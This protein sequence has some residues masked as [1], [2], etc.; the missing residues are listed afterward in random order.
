ME[1]SYIL[2]CASM[3]AELPLYGTSNQPD[4]TICMTAVKD[5]ARFV[6]KAIDLSTWPAEL[7]MCGDRMTVQ[8]LASLV[9]QLKSASRLDSNPQS[10][11]NNCFQ[12]QSSSTV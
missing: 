4:V 12:R 6:T 1:G 9:E 3:S 11:A 5:V 8:S 7:R 10:V 2:N